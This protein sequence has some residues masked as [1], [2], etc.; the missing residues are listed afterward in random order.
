MAGVTFHIW[1][2]SNGSGGFR[3]YTTEIVSRHGGAGCG[4][5]HSG[6]AGQR[7]SGAMELQSGQMRFLFSGN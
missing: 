5:P 4:S 1:R 2:G 6:G 7:S 3:E